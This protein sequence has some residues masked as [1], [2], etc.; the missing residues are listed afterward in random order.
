MPPMA[1]SSSTRVFGWVRWPRFYD[2][3]AGLARANASP[4]T[5]DVT[6]TVWSIPPLAGDR[7]LELRVNLQPRRQRRSFHCTHEVYN[8]ASAPPHAMVV[9][10]A[11]AHVGGGCFNNGFVQEESMVMQSTDFAVRLHRHRQTLREWE[12]VS[13]Q[14]VYMDAW[15]SREEAAKKQNMDTSKILHAQSPPLTIIAVDAPYMAHMGTG[16]RQ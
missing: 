2:H 14:G 13:Y 10:F 4:K 1:F 7:W 8:Y 9:D 3:V 12:A 6:S 15:W 11:N 5:T 16:T